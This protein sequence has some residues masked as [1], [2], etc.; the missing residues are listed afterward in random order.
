MLF[1]CK[2]FHDCWADCYDFCWNCER[3]VSPSIF[4]SGFLF[5]TLASFKSSKLD[6]HP[7]CIS[8]DILFGWVL[9]LHCYLPVSKGMLRIVHHTLSVIKPYVHIILNITTL[10]WFGFVLILGALENPQPS[11]TS[12]LVDVGSKQSWGQNKTF[13]REKVSLLTQK[14][15][16]HSLTN[17][18]TAQTGFYMF[19]LS[20]TYMMQK[21][22]SFHVAMQTS[23]SWCH[24]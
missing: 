1:I 16:S 2:I 11:A 14:C 24:K 6:S 12:S 4:L 18:Q 23:W 3:C 15:D 22:K 13:E 9:R 21:I 19:R 8:D 17:R 10:H 7:L 20:C 5:W